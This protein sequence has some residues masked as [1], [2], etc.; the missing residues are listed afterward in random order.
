MFKLQ[1]QVWAPLKEKA[2]IMRRSIWRGEGGSAGGSALF[3]VTLAI[4]GGSLRLGTLVTLLKISV[5]LLITKN[6]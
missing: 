1:G 4:S 3:N 2:S 6:I 5:A